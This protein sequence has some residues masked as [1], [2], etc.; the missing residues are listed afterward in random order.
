MFVGLLFI[1][2][3]YK[4]TPQSLEKMQSEIASRKA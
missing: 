4:I 1:I 2:F 3:L